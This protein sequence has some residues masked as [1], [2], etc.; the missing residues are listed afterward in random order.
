M[1]ESLRPHALAYASEGWQVVPIH[2]A[3]NGT[4]T[5]HKGASCTSPGKHPRTRG[6]LHDA[7]NDEMQVAEWWGT[8]PTANIGIVT[9]KVSGVVV[10]DVD[11]DKGGL[12]S[13][14][15][16]QAANGGPLE[17]W[18]VATG[19][20]GLHAYFRAPELEIGNRASFVPGVDFRGD[21]GYVIAPPSLHNSGKHYAWRVGV[22]DMVEHET[23][24]PWLEQ[25][26]RAPKERAVEVEAFTARF[27]DWDSQ[28]PQS[29]L[30][31]IGDD[32]RLRK[33]FNRD[34]RLKA[35]G[36]DASK[37]DFAVAC[38]L[39]RAGVPPPDCAHGVM[40]SRMQDPEAAQGMHRKA[41][42][43][44][45]R[46]V[47]GAV[48]AVAKE[49]AELERLRQ[50]SHEAWQTNY[51]WN[52]KGDTDRFLAIHGADLVYHPMEKRWYCWDGAA[53]V[54]DDERRGGSMGVESRLAQFL[55]DAWLLPK[56]CGDR[57]AGAKYALKIGTAGRMDAIKKISRHATSRSEAEL[58]ADPLL[59]NVANGVVDLATG[60]LLPH[61]R[62]LLQTKIAGAPYHEEA[63][64]ERWESFL[65]EVLPDEEVREFFGLCVGYSL[66]GIQPEQRFFF[67]HGPGATGKSTAIKAIQAAFGTYHRAADFST[68]LQQPGR[69]SNSASGDLARLA[70]VRMV[71]AVEVGHGA[72]LNT[73]LIKQ[74]S[75]GDTVT[76][77]KLFG[78]EVETAPIM[79]LWFGANDRPR[80]RVD[81][82]ALWRRLVPFHFNQVATQ[83]D[84]RLTER[85]TGRERPGILTWAIGQARRYLDLGALKL[86]DAC[87]EGVED[88]RRSSNPVQEFLDEETS[89][90]P[91]V[92]ERKSHVWDRYKSWCH[93]NQQKPMGKRAFRQ[94]LDSVYPTATLHGGYECW[95]GVVL[96]AR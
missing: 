46:T 83:I 49:Q 73:G 59:V 90:E 66:L 9:G 16:L 88:Y 21:G 33:L 65:T 13:W 35:M 92:S 42:D 60:K 89:E 70:R 95:E 75:G 39:L 31:A 18:V 29:V 61:D 71:S 80:G 93:D 30:E 63:R 51:P 27:S 19:G 8:W 26:I 25:L 74:L 22:E 47:V 82:D 45:E 11:A 81:D 94:T 1:S 58:D 52:E 96:L 12:A 76:A 34:K 10:V 2:E 91:L 69:H 72:H 20:G 77:R 85:L 50:E 67:V 5:C 32:A 24:P 7:T 44:F 38:A 17:C 37:V 79:S 15:A 86:P 56:F 41:H 36:E 14:D 84:A 78:D 53:F 55:D 87:V 68:F 57:E 48:E 6:G 64:S 62:S 3:K 23:L 43:Y 4:C 28:C 40:F 54:G